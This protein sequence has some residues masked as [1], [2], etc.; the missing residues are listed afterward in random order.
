MR[1]GHRSGRAWRRKEK[2]PA[3]SNFRGAR[4]CISLISAVTAGGHMRLMIKEKGGVNAEAFIEFLRRLMYRAK[5]HLEADTVG[6]TSITQSRRIQG[7]SEII[8]AVSAAQPCKGL[9]FLSEALP[10]N[11]PLDVHLLMYRLIQTIFGRALLTARS[12]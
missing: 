8:N 6:R 1:S 5:K 9:I 12:P 3:A 10:S 7:E 2:N 11:T 4:Y